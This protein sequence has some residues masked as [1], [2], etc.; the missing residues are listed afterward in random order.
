MGGKM[1]TGN[2]ITLSELEYAIFV[3]LKA[4]LTY[5]EIA[6][7]LHYSRDHIRNTVR[8]FNLVFAERGAGQL[9]QADGTRE[10][11]WLL[12]HYAPDIKPNHA[13]HILKTTTAT[14]R[15][16]KHEYN[17]ASTRTQYSPRA[18]TYRVTLD[19]THRRRNVQKQ[20]KR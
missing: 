6:N 2:E 18:S 14:F 19:D 9:L 7:E 16:Y 10:R 11:S 4:G 8:K 12:L 5:A 1:T 20:P 13:A 15:H 17:D 3:R